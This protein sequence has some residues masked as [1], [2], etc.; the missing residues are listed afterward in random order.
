MPY[1]TK[2]AIGGSSVLATTGF[3]LAGW[4]VGAITLVL[5]GVALVMLVR[6]G[7]AVRP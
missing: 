1:G 4:M 5:L 6:P 7:P 3:A 2:G